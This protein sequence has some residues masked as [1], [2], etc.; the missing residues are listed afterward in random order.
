MR[1]QSNEKLLKMHD[2]IDKMKIKNISN[3][4]SKISLEINQNSDDS[5]LY[6]AD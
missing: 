1:N 2:I 5:I 6:I 4:K 3:Q